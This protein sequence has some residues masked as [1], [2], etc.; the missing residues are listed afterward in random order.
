MGSQLKGKVG[1]KGDKITKG[2]VP[3]REFLL[4]SKHIQ[5]VLHILNN[6]KEGDQ[7]KYFDIT[8]DCDIFRNDPETKGNESGPRGF[9]TGGEQTT[10]HTASP[11]ANQTG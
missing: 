8:V 4:N 5:P 6:I 10:I 1:Q 2:L 11:W 9:A 7:P 3:V